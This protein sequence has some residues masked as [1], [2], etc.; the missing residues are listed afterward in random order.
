MW[1]DDIPSNLSWVSVYWQMFY[2]QK[3]KSDCQV[4][5]TAKEVLVILDTITW[6]TANALRF[7]G[8]STASL[9]DISESLTESLKASKT[10]K[11][12]YLTFQSASYY[13]YI[14][15]YIYIHIHIYSWIR[16]SITWHAPSIVQ[17]ISSH[18]VHHAGSCLLWAIS[19]TTCSIS[20]LWNQI[21]YKHNFTFLL[22][23]QHIKGQNVFLSSFPSITL[24]SS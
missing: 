19:S 16:R 8:I 3:S 23:M 2:G 24:T 22:T 15:I 20:V 11:K 7:N 4:I 18:G 17:F 9:H 5:S 6:S 21:E 14:Y 12:T 10:W 13:I 1:A